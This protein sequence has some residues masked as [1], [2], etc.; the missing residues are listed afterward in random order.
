[1]D[2]LSAILIIIG[3]V[4]F[5]TVSSIDNAVINAQV[6][7]TMSDRAKRWFLTWGLFVAVFAMRGLLPFA[8]IWAVNPGLGPIGA[9]TAAFSADPAVQES[10]EKS[11]PILLAGGGT[12]L[13]FLFFHWLFL[14]PKHFG[15]RGERTFAKLGVW[16]YAVV[17]IML[18]AIV[19]FALKIDPVMAFSAVIGSTA[20]FITHGFKEN[21]E[22][23]EAELLNDTGRSDLSKI[24]YLEAIDA[25]FSIDGVLGA[26]AFTL[27]IPLILIGNGIGAYVVREATV[28]GIEQ[29]KRY[30]YL[31][32]G[33]MYSVFFLGCVMLTDSFGFH[34][35]EWFTPLATIL[36]IYYFFMKSRAEWKADPAKVAALTGATIPG[37]KKA[38][39]SKGK[40]SGKK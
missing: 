16:F 26:F 34:I 25:T 5:E 1:M 31:K 19:W 13:L 30:I 7:A 33:A 24:F 15:L 37:A 21:A 28:R 11:A 14:E 39:P 10:V 35:P 8:I 18:A 27:S 4:L 29:I 2:I 36:I 9:I 20:F 6:L 3:L 23:A 38:S 12:F 40:K 22:K 32:N 17:S